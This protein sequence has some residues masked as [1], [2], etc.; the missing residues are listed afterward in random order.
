[1]SLRAFCFLWF[2]SIVPCIIARVFPIPLFFFFPFLLFPIWGAV[3]FPRCLFWSVPFFPL[4]TCGPT[5]FSWWWF[6][7]VRNQGRWVFSWVGFDTFLCSMSLLSIYQAIFRFRNV[8]FSI[9]LLSHRFL[10]LF[11][12]VFFIIRF[13]INSDLLVFG[14]IFFVLEFGL[15][16][17]LGI[18]EP[19]C[20]SWSAI[21]HP[22]LAFHWSLI[23][24]FHDNDFSFDNNKFY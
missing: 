5:G 10:F 24:V 8:F 11:R 18:G 1:M 16:H 6:L 19:V 17:V 4:R 2:F 21:T 3:T 14:I 12:Q 15:C 20:D 7:C 23:I 9:T 22:V 13:W